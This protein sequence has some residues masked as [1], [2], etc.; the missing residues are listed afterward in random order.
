MA[1]KMVAIDIDG[2]LINDNREIT[3]KTVEAIKKASAQGVKVVLCTGRPMTG[4]QAYL[5]Q[6]G[7]AGNDT[8]YVVSFNGALAQTTSGK[9]MVNYSLTFEDYADWNNY[10]L[11]EGVKSQI[12]TRDYI[13]TTNQDISPYTVYESELVS[14]PIRYRSMDE[15]ARMRDEYVVAKAMMV[16][17]K[18]NIDRAYNDL[19]EEFKNRFSIVRSEDFYLEFMNKAV[20]KG[21]AL[22]RLCE[23]LKIDPSEVMALGNAQNDDSMI[24]FAG[25]GVAM[26]NSIPGTMKIADDVTEDNNHDGVG[27]AIEK[28]VL[29]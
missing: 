25:T 24:E 5:E 6:L 21:Q 4:V 19:T 28:H 2:T 27:L 29:K 26:G 13:Y 7:L 1:I 22:K 12:E 23:E 18:E 14:M 16:D 11:K 3:P 17:S 9:V 20:S 10:C 8:E 15:M